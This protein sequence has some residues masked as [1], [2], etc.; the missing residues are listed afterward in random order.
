MNKGFLKGLLVGVVIAGIVGM[1]VSLVANEQKEK[2]PE[3]TTLVFGKLKLKPTGD[4]EVAEKLLTEKLLSAAKDIQGL[5]MT[6]LKWQSVPGQEAKKKPYQPDYVM[7]AEMANIGIFLKL[8]ASQPNA[9]QEYGT[10]M[11]AQAGAPEFE[12]Y[13]ILGTSAD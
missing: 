12:L 11:K 8:I 3:Y 4:A 5:K 7:M 13:Q 10:Q 1:C 6:A 2:A 9:L